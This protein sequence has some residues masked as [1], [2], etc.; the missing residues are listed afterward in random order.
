MNPQKHVGSK[1]VWMTSQNAEHFSGTPL[2]E[3][4]TTDVCIVGAGI[5]GLTAAYLLQKAGQSVV[6]LDAATIASGQTE[7][8]TA[9]L[10]VAL[11]TR[12]FELESYHGAK[13]ASLIA[14]SHAAAIDEIERITREEKI[15]CEFERLSGYLF[16][17]AAKDE[18]ELEKE[19]AACHRAGLTDVKLVE[20]KELLPLAKE[21]KALQFP[22]QAQ[23]NPMKYVQALTRLINL[24]GGKIYENTKVSSVSGGKTATVETADGLKITCKSA[25][26]A[27][28]S[29]INDIFA[30]HTKQAPYR[31]YAISLKYKSTSQTRALYWDTCDPYHYIRFVG[32][33]LLIVGGEDHKTGQDLEPEKAYA[34]LETWI[35]AKLP[36]VGDIVD[37]WSGQVM[38]SMDG[39]GFIGHNPLDRNNVYVVTGD[40]GNGMTHGTLGAMLIRDQITGK[41][42]EW[43]KVYTPN[44]V[45][46]KAAKEFITENANVGLQYLDWF[47]PLAHKPVEEL[48][49][50]EGQV[51]REGLNVVAISKDASGAIFKCSAICPH[52]GGIVRWNQAEQSWDCPC[53]G[54]RF[55]HTGKVIEGPATLDLATLT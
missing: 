13:G 28:N 38:E 21:T 34:N 24:R 27:T 51:M 26:V 25:V 50:L 49:A 42:N 20:S 1:S 17:E 8:T 31:T 23:F 14:E 46:P 47:K 4:Q 22:K 54:S 40:S 33:D 48:A 30:I 3:N 7:R 35:R 41:Q 9:H 55:T 11:G 36:G 2:F 44:R 15:D 19:L 16:G 6:V 39:V 10:S 12:Y 5:A 29:P 43:E 18:D 52:L 45:R 53:H 37:K 32:D